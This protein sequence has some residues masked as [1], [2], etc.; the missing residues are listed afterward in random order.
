MPENCSD[1]DVRLTGG[2]F[3][4]H[5]RVEVCRN[6]AWGSVCYRGSSFI[7]DAR[8]ICRQIGLPNLGR[9]SQLLHAYHSTCSYILHAVITYRTL[10]SPTVPPMFYTFQCSSSELSLNQCEN[11]AGASTS[12]ISCRLDVIGMQCDGTICINEGI[13]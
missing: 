7:S 13:I 9:C 12:V 6:Q 11:S 4:G 10:A 1:G 2:S 3:F 5:G 8:V